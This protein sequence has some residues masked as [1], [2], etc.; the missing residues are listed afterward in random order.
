MRP[1]EKRMRIR[2]RERTRRKRKRRWH[3][4]PLRTHLTELLLA[5]FAIK[6]SGY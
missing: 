6:K 2:R 5:R 3:D 4:S 1:D